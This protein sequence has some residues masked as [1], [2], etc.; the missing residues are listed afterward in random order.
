MPWQA[1]ITE[2]A[3]PGSK[4]DDLRAA[5]FNGE[6]ERREVGALLFGGPGLRR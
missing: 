5:G 6:T 1:T 4:A 2:D 3:C